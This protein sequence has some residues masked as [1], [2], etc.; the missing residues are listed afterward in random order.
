MGQSL[1]HYLVCGCICYSTD[2][3]N[4]LQHDIQKIFGSSKILSATSPQLTITQLNPVLQLRSR[5]PPSDDG[6]SNNEIDMLQS[7][8]G[9][10]GGRSMLDLIL[11]VRA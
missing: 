4:N 10:G 9:A 3:F 7:L 11:N 6:I 8:C 2:S 1:E 5:I